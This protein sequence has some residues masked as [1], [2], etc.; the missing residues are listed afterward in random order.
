MFV[1]R[2]TR[3]VFVLASLALGATAQAHPRLL[4][5][6]PTANSTVFKPAKI[7]MKFSE[8]LIAP[9]SSADVI[10]T[11]MPGRSAKPMKISGVSSAIAADR[12]TMVLSFK[13]QLTT[14]TYRVN[15]HVV[16]SDTHRIQGSFA[17]AV[18]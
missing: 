18:K 6:T 8:T 13:Q 10:M 7:A 4:S 14:G 17:F 2:A 9:M 5:S 3:T 15:W 12:K 11:K 1:S 16:S